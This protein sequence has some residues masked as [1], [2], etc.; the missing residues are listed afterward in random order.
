[1]LLWIRALLEYWTICNAIISWG[2]RNKHSLELV[3]KLPSIY[4]G[5]DHCYSDLPVFPFKFRSGAIV[6]LDWIYVFLEKRTKSLFLSPLPCRLFLREEIKADEN[7]APTLIDCQF[8]FLF[9]S[10]TV[11][12]TE[13]NQYELKC[14]HSPQSYD[15]TPIMRCGNGNNWLGIIIYF[16]ALFPKAGRPWR[17]QLIRETRMSFCHLRGYKLEIT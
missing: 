2:R 6:K 10:R 14:L 3:P 13:I 7:I 8:A 11:A 16:A 9:I 4:V 17:S 5:I 12:S 15:S 1:M